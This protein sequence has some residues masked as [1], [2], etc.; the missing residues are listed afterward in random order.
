MIKYDKYDLENVEDK[1]K[2]KISFR[3]NNDYMR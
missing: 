2:K 3:E 1:D